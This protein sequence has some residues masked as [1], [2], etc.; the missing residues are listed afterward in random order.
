[1]SNKRE[2][3]SFNNN[4]DRNRDID[5]EKVREISFNLRELIK[6]HQALI[7]QLEKICR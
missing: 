3:V 4:K 1:M 2:K 7:E 6:V 5:S